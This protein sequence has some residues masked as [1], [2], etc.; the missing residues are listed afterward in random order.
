MAPYQMQKKV[1][2]VFGRAPAMPAPVRVRCLFTMKFH[3]KELLDNCV[4]VGLGVGPRVCVYAN[5]LSKYENSLD[6]GI[7]CA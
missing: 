1:V 3:G 5:T 2:F 4:G 7:V 6:I